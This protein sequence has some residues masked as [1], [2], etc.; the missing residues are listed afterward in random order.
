MTYTVVGAKSLRSALLLSAASAAI[1]SLTVPA[2]AQDQSAPETVVVTGSRIPQQGLYSS[3]PVTAIGQQEMKFQGTTDVTTLLDSLPSVTPSFSN[4]SSAFNGTLGV[5]NVNLRNLGPSRTLVLVDGKRLMPGDPVLPFPDLNQ[6][7]AQLVDHVEVDTGGASA[8]YGSDALAGVVNFIMRKDFEGIEVDGQ[9]SVNNAPNNGNLHGVPFSTLD[10]AVNT[11]A[12]PSDWWGGAEGDATLIMGVN[13]DND[14]GNITGWLGYRHQQPVQGYDRDFSNC[15]LSNSFTSTEACEGSSNLNRWISFDNLAKGTATQTADFFETGTGAPGSGTFIPYTG[16]PQEHFNFGAPA[17]IVQGETRYNAG[18]NAHYDVSK[19]LD[20]YSTFMFDDDEN[21]TISSPVAVFLGAGTVS[22]NPFMGAVA[23][24]GYI[25]TNCANPLMT[26]SENLDLCGS[27]PG[28]AKVTVTG[29]NGKP[30]TYYGGQG[31][32]IPGQSLLYIGRRGIEVGGRVTDTTRDAY[33]MVIGGKGD[34]GDGWS[35]DVFAQYG[36]TVFQEELS[37]DWSKERV[38]N[39]LEVDPTTGGCIG[40]P[41]GCEPLDIFD[42]LGSLNSASGK[43]GLDYITISDLQ[44]GY[45]E[46]EVMGGNITGDLGEWGGQSPW[47]KNPIALVFGTEYREE[48][49]KFQV[50]TT[51]QSGDTYGG[52][53][54]EPTPQSAFDVTEGYTEV[55]IPLVQEMPYV[56]DFTVHGAY[57]Y[58]SYNTVGAVHSYSYDLTYQPVDDFRF[59]AAYQRAT[60]A[61][62]VL[63]FFKPQNTEL[64]SGTD[65]CATSTAGACA[66][67]PNAGTG[68]TGILACPAGQ[69]NQRVG[70]TSSLKPETSD[71]RTIG[72]VLTP[73]FFD[74]FNATIDYYSINVSNYIGQYG[75][76]TVL[77]GCYGPTATAATEKLFCPLVHRNGS[78]GIYGG[79][80]SYVADLNTNLPYI[81][82][83][84]VDFESNYTSSFD[85]WGWSPLVGLGGLT[86]NFRGTW[87]NQWTESPESV[88]VPNYFNCAGKYGAICGST[89]GTGGVLPRWRHSLRLTWTT[90]WDVDISLNWRHISAVGLDLNSTNPLLNSVLTGFCQSYGISPCRDNADAQIKAFDYFDLAVDWTVREGVDLRAGVNNIFALNPPVVSASSPNVSPQPFG[91]ANTYPGIYDILGRQVFVAATVKY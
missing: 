61:P 47:A 60:R 62:N 32:V 59:R 7:P 44:E 49:L 45:T 35:Y 11:P 18:F 82:T 16:T 6:I 87:L 41:T 25:E 68:P 85:D 36:R 73:T 46:E 63:E 83:K 75:S 51:N 4:V 80:T 43:A 30:F 34:L 29:A 89:E 23:N 12:A 58:S 77:D 81:K 9:Y 91:S 55:R 78:G 13:T 50:D 52:A 40:S 88:S 76:Q 33:R 48:T 64:F 57:R 1:T 28:D 65:P 2:M 24:P 38:Q 5:S 15:T 72:V 86:A 53:Q 21:H 84:G 71:T 27:L 42:G 17:A 90:P 66:G 22:A 26:P 39:A 3:S 69:C 8:V 14:K 20:I 10:A 19:Q 31:N 54:T 79:P 56:E 37:N 74:G 70:G 67:V